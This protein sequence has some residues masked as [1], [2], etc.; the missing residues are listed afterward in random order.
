MKNSEQ[1]EN[2]RQAALKLLSDFDIEKVPTP[3]RRIAKHL[4]IFVEYTPLD[5]ALSGMAMIRDGHRLVWVN[6]LHH[7]NRQR[8][9]L[10]HEI[11]HHVLHEEFLK[12]GV[13]VDKAMLRRDAL[14]SEGSARVEIEANNFAS[15]L[16]MPEPM[17]QAYFGSINLEDQAKVAGVAARFKVSP[18]A[19]QFRLLR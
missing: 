4:D 18:A 10:A 9:T 2:A 17:M 3:L 15:E 7:P 5:D 16:L 1:I 12:E 19:L 6:S 13:H 14:S 8:F 11:G